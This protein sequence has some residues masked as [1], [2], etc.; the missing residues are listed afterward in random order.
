M[1][2]IPCAARPRRRRAAAFRLPFGV[3]YVVL[4]RPTRL[5]RFW[6]ACARLF[7]E[8]AL[9]ADLALKNDRDLADIGLTRADVEDAAGL[10]AF[11]HPLDVLATRARARAA[12]SFGRGARL[13]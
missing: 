11:G 1:T 13:F 12:Q 10:G 7:A 6:S 5:S 4:A 2:A 9:L 3:G 8:K